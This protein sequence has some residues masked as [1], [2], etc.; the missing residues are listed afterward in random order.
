MLEGPHRS[1]TEPETKMCMSSLVLT[2]MKSQANT[3]TH[4]SMSAHH[5]FFEG[6]SAAVWSP[7]ANQLPKQKIFTGPTGE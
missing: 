1:A 3:V 5:T 7:C 2:F 6:S 4:F